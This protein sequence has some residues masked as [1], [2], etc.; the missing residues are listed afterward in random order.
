MSCKHYKKLTYLFKN[1][2]AI[3][4][5]GGFGAIGSALVFFPVAFVI[6]ETSNLSFTT[7]SIVYYIVFHSYHFFM[8]WL[9]SMMRWNT[10]KRWRKNEK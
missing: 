3:A 10:N 5:V 9:G 4:L 1:L 7:D 2:H 8:V 6:G